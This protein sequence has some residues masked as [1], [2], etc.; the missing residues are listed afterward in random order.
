MNWNQRFALTANR[1]DNLAG[2][3]PNCASVKDL[4]PGV[5]KRKRPLS[6]F[7]PLFQTC[8]R[9]L[10]QRE[11]ET[12]SHERIQIKKQQFHES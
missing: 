2:F 9:R 4:N 1:L 3:F 5:G 6:A 7:F 12:I 8:S 10:S 11:K